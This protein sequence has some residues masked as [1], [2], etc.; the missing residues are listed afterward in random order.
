MEA[1]GYPWFRT[2]YGTIE[3]GSYV[4][5]TAVTVNKLAFLVHVSSGV[6]MVHSDV[7]FYKG[8][9]I[10]AFSLA[11]EVDSVLTLNETIASAAFGMAVNN[12]KAVGSPNI[13]MSTTNGDADDGEQTDVEEIDLPHDEIS[14]SLP[15]W[16]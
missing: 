7:K 3:C 12:T 5:G 13:G 14:I 10:Y 4:L 9:F 11:W 8:A 1:I 6:A 15:P 16:F 2:L